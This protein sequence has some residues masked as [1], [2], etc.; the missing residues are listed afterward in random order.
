M[1]FFG[2][3]TGR[4]AFGIFMTTRTKFFDTRF[5]LSLKQ[6]AGIGSIWAAKIYTGF[7][8]S[9]NYTQQF[10]KLNHIIILRAMSFAHK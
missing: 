6:L 5:T 9:P 10:D 2:G 7:F 3:R 8:G 1:A 4:Q